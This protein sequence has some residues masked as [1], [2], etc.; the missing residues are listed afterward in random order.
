MPYCECGEHVTPDF[1]RVFGDP[2]GDVL[3]CLAC[4]EQH[5]LPVIQ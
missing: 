3:G 2:E 5:E 4:A 1:V